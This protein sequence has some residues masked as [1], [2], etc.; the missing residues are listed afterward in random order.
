[1][2]PDAA[3]PIMRVK[4]K[5][6]VFKMIKIEADIA[7]VGLGPAGLAACISAA[8]DG[9]SVIGFEKAAVVGGAANMG[10]GPFGVESSYKNRL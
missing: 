9:K 5:E 2:P 8:E 4:K 3:P 7:V 1:M 6:E 10:G